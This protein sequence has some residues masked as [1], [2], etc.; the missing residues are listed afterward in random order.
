MAKARKKT[1]K[2][3]GETPGEKGQAHYGKAEGL[4]G[5]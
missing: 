4:Q 1:R 5:G 2:G 3:S